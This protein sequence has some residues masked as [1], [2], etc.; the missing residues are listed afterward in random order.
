MIMRIKENLNIIKKS[1][2]DRYDE[3][4]KNDV[5]G[6]ICLEFCPLGSISEGTDDRWYHAG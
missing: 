4:S 5:L 6:R 2:Q 3:E 1:T